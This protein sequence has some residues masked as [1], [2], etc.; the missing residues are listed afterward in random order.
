MIEN[1]GRLVYHLKTPTLKVPSMSL[2]L[3]ESEAPT[4]AIWLLMVIMCY[5]GSVLP[6][7]DT[8]DG[9]LK[10]Y[11]TW[12][13]QIASDKGW[14]S[15]GSSVSPSWRLR[16]CLARLCFADEVL[17]PYRAIELY[18]AVEVG[19]FDWEMILNSSNWSIKALMMVLCG[20]G[21]FYRGPMV[22]AKC[23]C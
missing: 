22:G 5:C 8:S 1:R 9:G 4:M 17:L 13:S 7:K 14:E 12:S 16:R 10:F 20:P 21:K 15:I 23:S 6:L 2:N 19:H 11:G 18:L 3:S